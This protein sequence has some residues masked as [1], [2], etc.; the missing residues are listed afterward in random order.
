MLKHKV[1]IGF[2]KIDGITFKLFVDRGNLVLEDN[3]MKFKNWQERLKGFKFVGGENSYKYNIGTFWTD[4]EIV[5][6][7]NEKQ[8][9]IIFE[10]VKQSP[11]NNVNKN[12]EKVK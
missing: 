12:T 4:K 3:S 5:K 6:Y 9:D 8:D 1:Q 10:L 7:L 11:I 2:K